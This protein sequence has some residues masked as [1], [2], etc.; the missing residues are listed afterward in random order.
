[1][2]DVES[3]PMRKKIVTL[4][5]GASDSVQPVFGRAAHEFGRLVARAGWVLRTGAGSGTSIMGRA[6]DGALEEGGRVEGVILSKFWDVRHRRLHLLV[7]VD[8]F[9]LR[10]AGLLRGV[11]GVAIFPG[12][13]G[14]LDE[15]GDV[16]ALKQNGFLDV[17]LVLVNLRGYFRSLLT[18]TR[19]AVRA[20]FMK[21]EDLRLFQ[22]VRSVDAAVR[23]FR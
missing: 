5:G 9:A 16:L 21:P 11:S 14:T 20:N 17:P 15:F 8:T 18:W 12:G 1:L 4:F 7:S 6:A 19:E 22:V 23:A 10:K 2:I 3:I 13:V